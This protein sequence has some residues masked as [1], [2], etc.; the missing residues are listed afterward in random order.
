MGTQLLIFA[1]VLFLTSAQLIE[2]PRVWYLKE[3]AHLSTRKVSYYIGSIQTSGSLDQASLE[4]TLPENPNWE[5]DHPHAMVQLSYCQDDFRQECVFATNYEYGSLPE[6]YS[7]I[8]WDI[9]P[10][11]DTT[12]LR[13]LGGYSATIFSLEISLLTG[14]DTQFYAWNTN[15]PFQGSSMVGK[16]PKTMNQHWKSDTIYNVMDTE[17]CHFFL[18]YSDDD[19][20]DIDV[21]VQTINA[22]GPTEDHSLVQQWACIGSLTNYEWCRWTIADW[23]NGYITSFNVLNVKDATNDG[24]IVVVSGYGANVDGQNHFMISASEN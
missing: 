10:S 18:P 12:Y 20:V 6:L 5:A 16:T 14:H 2:I 4:I 1:T 21:T 8:I 17:F 19:T 15:W 23:W 22:N 9:N 11:E 7:K 3:L 13:I 24:I